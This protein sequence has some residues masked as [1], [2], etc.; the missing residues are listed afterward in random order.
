MRFGTS[1]LRS[2]TPKMRFGTPTEEF[3]TPKWYENGEA[4]NG[5]CNLLKKIVSANTIRAIKV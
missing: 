3:R 4:A 5:E 2:E 1:N